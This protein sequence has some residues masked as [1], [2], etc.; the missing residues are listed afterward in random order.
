LC[1]AYNF[2]ANLGIR[3]IETINIEKQKGMEGQ[4]IYMVEEKK[5]LSGKW[6]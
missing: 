4:G 2:K 5:R 6:K 1:E 3:K